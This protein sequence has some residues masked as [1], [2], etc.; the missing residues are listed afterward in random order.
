MK[1]A[2][3]TNS[4][5][6]VVKNA[7]SRWTHQHCNDSTTLMKGSLDVL[8]S[9]LPSNPPTPPTKTSEALRLDLHAVNKELDMMKQRWEE[10]KCHLLGERAVLQ[11]AVNWM[12]ME[13]WSAKD[14]AKRATEVSR[15]SRADTQEVERAKVVIADLEAELQA[16]RTRLRQM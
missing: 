16:E 8:H 3:F 11:D 12:N 14:K 6:S 5:G 13:I 15:Q 2:D 4:K 9:G 7:W 1:S 10:E